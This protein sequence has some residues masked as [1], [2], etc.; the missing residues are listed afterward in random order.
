[1]IMLE[2][3]SG[4]IT[5]WSSRIRISP[6]KPKYC[7]SRLDRSAYSLTAIPKQAPGRERE[8]GSEATFPNEAITCFVADYPDGRASDRRTGEAV[9]RLPSS[10]G[11]K[12]QDKTARL[13]S[14]VDPA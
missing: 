3:M 9:G 13:S 5:S 2:T 7:L 11:Q 10:A 1:M 6:G 4:R 14:R 8:D 12:N